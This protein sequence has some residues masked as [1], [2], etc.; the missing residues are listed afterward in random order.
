[1]SPVLAVEKYQPSTKQ[2]SGLFLSLKM[3]LEETHRYI[4]FESQI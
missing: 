3:V 4:L 1:M 2:E